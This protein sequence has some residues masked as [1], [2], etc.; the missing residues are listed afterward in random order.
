[1]SENLKQII[2][3]YDRLGCITRT[4]KFQVLNGGQNV[5]RQPIEAISETKTSHMYNATVPT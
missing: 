4:L 5:T 3:K 2:I 1:M